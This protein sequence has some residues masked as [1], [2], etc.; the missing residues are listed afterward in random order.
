MKL[1]AVILF[2]SIFFLLYG[3][4]NYYI[5]IRGYQS[6][7]AHAWLRPYYV[8]LFIILSI[9][10][11]LGRTLENYWLNP[12]SR[13][14]T[15]I[16]AFWLAA[17]LYF[18]I[19][20]ALIDL[21]R[22]VNHFFPFYP[23][24]IVDNYPV[25]KAI[26]GGIMLLIVLGVLS[27]GYW[28][29]TEIK[30]RS[31]HYAVKKKGKPD[32]RLKI[33][34]MSDIHLGSIIGKSKFDEIV[35]RVNI[36]NPDVILLP[37]DIL[38]EDI[39][40]VIHDNVGESLLGLRSRYGTFA[41]TGNHEYIG[42]VETAC[43]YLGSHG[44]RVLRDE[45]VLVGEAFYLVGREDRSISGFAKKQRKPLSELM[46]DV[47]HEFP[48]ILMDH[49]PFN[50]REASI[51]RVD[52]QLSG[53]THHGQLWPLNFIT[54][55][56]YELSWGEKSIGDTFYYVSCGVGTWGPPVRTGNHPEIVS[57]TLD[58]MP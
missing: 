28:N 36:L 41:V 50:L 38:D 56:V 29:A 2:Y 30:T 37:G 45:S 39:S 13:T 53:H 40:P 12:L 22:S 21:I 20:I 24:S 35:S 18:V 43:E 34:S 16:G 5:Y 7:S 3:S 25:A 47:D 44:V 49:Q 4:V 42:G 6:L 15:W 33:V 23:K 19:G 31:L 26:A 10:F 51:N 14:F 48:V 46:S 55:M 27:F 17:I 52:L 8:V 11:I 9:S 1:S 58:F 54:E 32:R 57:V